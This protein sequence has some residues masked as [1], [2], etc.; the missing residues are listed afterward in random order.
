[1]PY[2]YEAT[3]IR[4]SNSDMIDAMKIWADEDDKAPKFA[5]NEFTERHGRFQKSGL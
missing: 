4:N 1:M 2:V 5:K 3:L